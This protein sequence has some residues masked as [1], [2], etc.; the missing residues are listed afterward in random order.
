MKLKSFLFKI[1]I[2][3]VVSFLVV[4]YCIMFAN[5]NNK[6][7]QND[8]RIYNQEDT[9]FLSKGIK[10][11]VTNIEFLTAQNINEQKDLKA[12]IDDEEIYGVYQITIKLQNIVDSNKQVSLYT[13]C[14]E[15]LNYTSQFDIE[16]FDFLNSNKKMEFMIGPG[17]CY[18]VI[19]PVV[20]SKYSFLNENFEEICEWEYYFVTSLY[21]VKNMVKLKCIEDII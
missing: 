2:L 11:K 19:L 18:S 15:S 1:I 3:V 10:C 12:V 5:T 6:Y 20:I 14:L 8:D 16:L 9:F 7:K 21:P 4:C 17:E 13:D